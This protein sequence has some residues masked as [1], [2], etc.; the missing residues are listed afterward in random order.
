MLRE[1]HT[2][3]IDNTNCPLPCIF[4]SHDHHISYT[5]GV[6]IEDNV[7]ISTE[8]DYLSVHNY[9][10]GRS[11]NTGQEIIVHVENRI[12]ND[13]KDNNVNDNGKTI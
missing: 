9:I 10:H 11:S 6:H 2:F 8:N 13:N 3:E 4:N 12:E 5:S 1:Y 7:N